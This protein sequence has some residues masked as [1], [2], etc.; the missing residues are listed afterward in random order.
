MAGYKYKGSGQHGGFV[1]E[2]SRQRS[3][4]TDK[5]LAARLAQEMADVPFLC[6]DE[7]CGRRHPLREHAACRAAAYNSDHC[8]FGP[9]SLY[10]IRD[11]CT[12]PRH[13][14]RP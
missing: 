12:N 9:G 10:C 7:T 14:A 5:A 11:G 2:G 8:E 6:D 13:K 4:D 3:D 1:R